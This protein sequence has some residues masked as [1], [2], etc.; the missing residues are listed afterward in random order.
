[1]PSSPS[2]DVA[3]TQVT[4][5]R[6]PRRLQVSPQFMQGADERGAAP[7]LVPFPDSQEV[8]PRDLALAWESLV[9]SGMT[10]AEPQT[11][12]LLAAALKESPNDPAIL[13]ALGYIEQKHGATENARELYQRALRADPDS[14]DAAT[15]LG[16]I[17]AQKGH[18]QE[19]VKLWQD[20]FQ[21]APDRSSIGMNMARVYC[22]SEK[23]DE[24]R[25]TLVR[26]LEFNPDLDSAKKILW[27]LN[28]SPAS[29][30]R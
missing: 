21:R 16:V 30:W 27:E 10:A 20:A 28:R 7:K 14:I 5:H 15:N 23:Y 9:E 17:E 25:K 22:Q 24:A 13:A 29:C 1:M 12:K 4:D 8:D 11:Q 19:A 3:H 2:T 26:V 18:L 6:I